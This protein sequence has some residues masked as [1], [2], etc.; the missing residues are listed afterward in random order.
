MG[1]VKLPI[2]G[3]ASR[4]NKANMESLKWKAEALH[5]QKE[6]LVNEYSGMAY[7]MRNELELKKKQL[8]LY[9]TTIIPALQKNFRTMQLGYGQNTEELFM[10]YDAWE[11]LNMKQLQYFDLMG[12]ALQLQVAIER[13]IEKN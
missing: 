5:S 2:T 1:M 11:A 7:G 6:M 9:E 4:M 3:W 13:L 10:L 8:Q 12:Q